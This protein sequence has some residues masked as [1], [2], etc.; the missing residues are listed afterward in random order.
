MHYDH[1]LQ[2]DDPHMQVEAAEFTAWRQR[3]SQTTLASPTWVKAF[4]NIASDAASR[5]DRKA[6]ALSA[7]RFSVWVKEGPGRGLKRQ[8]LISRT[9]TGWIPDKVA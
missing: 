1:R 6:T 5:A 7:E 8:H 4:I 2:V 3:L 9:A